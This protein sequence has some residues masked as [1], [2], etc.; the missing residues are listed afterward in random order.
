MQVLRP[1]GPNARSVQSLQEKNLHLLLSGLR[2]V[3]EN[4]LHGGHRDQGGVGTGNHDADEA[5]RGV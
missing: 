5:L 1:A 3:P 4:R 2:Q